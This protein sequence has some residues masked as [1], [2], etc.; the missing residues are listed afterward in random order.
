[1]QFLCAVIHNPRAPSCTCT[2]PFSSNPVFEQENIPCHTLSA[3]TRLIYYYSTFWSW[4]TLWICISLCLMQ[5]AASMFF[6]NTRFFHKCFIIFEI[7]HFFGCPKT[8]FFPNKTPRCTCGNY[9]LPSVDSQCFIKTALLAVRAMSSLWKVHRWLIL[10]H[11]SLSQRSFSGRVKEA[12]G[13]G[14]S[15]RAA[16]VSLDGWR[17]SVSSGV[18]VEVIGHNFTSGWWKVFTLTQCTAIFSSTLPRV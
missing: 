18:V 9:K 8:F 5:F 6:W 14:Q 15:Q 1:M 2:V 7:I 12:A 11:I 10:C 4:K 16:R 3:S 13:A 17:V